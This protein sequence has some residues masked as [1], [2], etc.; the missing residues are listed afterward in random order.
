MNAGGGR[1]RS[2]LV[3]SRDDSASMAS[4]WNGRLN[5]DRKPGASR[6]RSSRRPRRGT[7]RDGDPPPYS[8]CFI[9]TDCAW[10]NLPVETRPNDIDSARWTTARTPTTGV[11][12]PAA[13]STSRSS[14]RRPSAPAPRDWH[15]AGLSVKTRPMTEWLHAQQRE[16]ITRVELRPQ[17]LG[18]RAPA[19]RL[20]EAVA[21]VRGVE[22]RCLAQRTELVGG[23]RCLAHRARWRQQLHTRERS[24]PGYGSGC[25]TTASTTVKRP[26]L[27]A[28]PMARIAIADA[29]NPDCAAGCARRRAGRASA[30]RASGR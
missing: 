20:R 30:W 15:R 23:H 10:R 3:A 25:S 5:G 4:S 8:L 14:P 13:S 22:R 12:A 29:A 11:R 26:V 9:R 16:R 1:I 24:A 2:D 27:A 28:M 17:R 19:E 7:R 21:D 18:E 6:N